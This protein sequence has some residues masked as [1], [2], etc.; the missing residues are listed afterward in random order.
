MDTIS[1]LTVKFSFINDFSYSKI[2]KLSKSQKT[3]KIKRYG[4]ERF[5][6]VDFVWINL[7]VT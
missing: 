2:V 5:S 1:I 7:M 6:K 3:K 4:K